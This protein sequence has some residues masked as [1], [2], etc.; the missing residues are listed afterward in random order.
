MIEIEGQE[1]VDGGSTR[2]FF[3]SRVEADG[4]KGEGIWIANDRKNVKITMQNM[5]VRE[6]KKP[7]KVGIPRPDPLC[8]A[9]AGSEIG[10]PRTESK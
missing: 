3:W 5:K 6:N 7:E 2:R 4:K 1:R 9:S 8:S 10:D